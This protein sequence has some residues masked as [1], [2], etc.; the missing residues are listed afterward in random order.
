MDFNWL[1][2]FQPYMV[3]LS[4]AGVGFGIIWGAMP[5]LSTNMAM[6]LALGLTYKMDPN[7]AVLFLLSILMG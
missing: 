1:S 3:L 5:A 7:I 2:I 4:L 6:A